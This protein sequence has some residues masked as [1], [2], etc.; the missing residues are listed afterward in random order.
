ME[1]SIPSKDRLP[2]A[3]FHQEA[4][5]ILGV[6]WSVQ[7]LDIYV[8]NLKSLLILWCLGDALAI[9]ASDD[10]SAFEFWVG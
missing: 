3:I 4:Y 1:K 8:P 10:R 9:L 6:A 2:G 5:A 7:S